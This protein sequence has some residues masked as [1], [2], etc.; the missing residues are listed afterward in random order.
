MSDGQG[1]DLGKDRPEEPAAGDPAA[2][3]PGYGQPGYGQPGYDQPYGQPGY[4]QPP[5]GYPQGGYPPPYPP[6]PPGGYPN[7]SYPPGQQYPPPYPPAGQYPPG[8]PPGQYP[9]GYPPFQ[10]PRNSGKAI[11]VLT[12]GIAS[13]IVLFTC[14]VGFIPAIVAL[15]LAPGA[16]REI[17]ES[18][19]ALTGAGM[20]Q[21]GK[22]CAWVTIA[23]TVVGLAAIAALVASTGSWTDDFG[24]FST[25]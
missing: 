15:C 22:I 14:F 5:A 3:Q 16:K 1:W 12:C 20:I 23:F 21:A 4:G 6:P 18:N 9:P 25:F 17:A 19:G 2:G 8:Y 7:Q 10:Q 11:G 24:T 13:L